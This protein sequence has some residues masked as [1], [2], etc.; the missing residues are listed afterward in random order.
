MFI[1]VGAIGQLA[2]SAPLPTLTVS[3]L[4]QVF[5]LFWTSAADF[6]EGTA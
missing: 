3:S 4:G 2:L 6:I 5:L 1:I